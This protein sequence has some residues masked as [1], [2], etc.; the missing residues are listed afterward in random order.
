MPTSPPNA[1]CTA[2]GKGMWRWGESLEPPRC[3]SCRVSSRM[4][5][6]E[7]CGTHFRSRPKHKDKANEGR[8]CSKRCLGKAACN[9]SKRKPY[10]PR[11]C[12]DCDAGT[13]RQGNVPLC[14]SCVERRRRENSSK[15]AHLR[16]A[17]K[18]EVE[19]ESY[20]LSEI[21]ARDK[22]VCQLCRR[23]VAMKQRAPHPKSPALDH[24]IPLSRG[25]TDTRA[26]IQLAHA[27]CN[28]SKGNRGGGEQLALIG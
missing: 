17:V 13:L 27:A 6:C 2:C 20:T 21:A 1:E 12:V 4:R 9:V 18:L 7:T 14:D 19:S 22:Y 11:V 16:R 3:R 15:Q 23:R 28:W 8:Y 24:V 5:I 25:G 10:G 26:N